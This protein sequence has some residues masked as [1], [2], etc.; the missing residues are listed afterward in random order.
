MGKNEWSFSFISDTLYF[1]EHFA[2]CR[3]KDK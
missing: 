2:V 1:T 3:I